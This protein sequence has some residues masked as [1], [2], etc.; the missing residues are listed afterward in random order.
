MNNQIVTADMLKN[1]P[2]PAQRYLNY[3]S[4]VGQPW[5]DTVRVKYAGIFRLKADKPWMPIKAEQVYT[6]NPPGFHWQ[7]R[8]K[9]FGLWLFKGDDTYKVGHGHM[10]GKIAGVYTIFDARRRIGSGHKDALMETLDR[11]FST[12]GRISQDNGCHNSA[13]SIA[14]AAH[15]APMAAK[16]TLISV[17]SCRVIKCMGRL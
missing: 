5:I 1:L 7:A 14:N 17:V 4:V 15:S 13:S 8:L 2:E 3:T 6:T 9:L 11:R 10:F 12:S 16:I